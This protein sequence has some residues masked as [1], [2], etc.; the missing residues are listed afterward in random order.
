MCT[1]KYTVFLLYI[2]VPVFIIYLL[3]RSSLRCTVFP[4]FEI[5]GNVL[6]SSKQHATRVLG[7][8]IFSIFSNNGKC[9][10]RTGQWTCLLFGLLMKGTVRSPTTCF[11]FC[12][13]IFD[14][15]LCQSFTSVK[16]SFR[17][18]DVVFYLVGR[19]K[20]GESN[21]KKYLSKQKRIGRTHVKKKEQ[22]VNKT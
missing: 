1:K 9:K 5:E 13:I 12:A 4:G 15:I 2:H 21:A 18:E 11:V 22:V 10:S 16:M 8:N 17:A 19:N 6:P 14:V 7:T 20:Q 3:C